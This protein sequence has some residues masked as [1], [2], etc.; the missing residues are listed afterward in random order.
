MFTFY[1][2]PD[3]LYAEQDQFE[4]DIKVI[5]EKNYFSEWLVELFV[6]TQKLYFIHPRIE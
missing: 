1:E 5:L 3:T 4:E 6:F 2:N